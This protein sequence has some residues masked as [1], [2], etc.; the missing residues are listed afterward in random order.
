[1][2]LSLVVNYMAFPPTYQLRLEK[3]LL[4]SLA[5]TPAP[6]GNSTRRTEEISPPMKPARL[7]A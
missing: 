2:D 5:Q 3:D 4:V 1:M 6:L 7:K